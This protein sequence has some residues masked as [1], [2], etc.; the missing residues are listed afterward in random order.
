[1]GYG[2]GM[3]KKKQVMSWMQGVGGE[4]AD[5]AKWGIEEEVLMELVKEGKVEPM[6]YRLKEEG[7]TLFPYSL[8]ESPLPLFLHGWFKDECRE[9]LKRLIEDNGVR[10]VVELGSWLGQSTLYMA[11]LLPEGG[12]VYA[13]DHWIDSG[14][15]EKPCVYKQFLSNVIRAQLT[16]RVVPIR[17]T[18]TEA[19]QDWEIEVDLIYVDASH[20]EKDVYQD[21]SVWYPIAKRCG[22]VLCGDDYLWRPEEGYPVQ[23]ALKR[24]CEKMGLTHRN[25]GVFWEILLK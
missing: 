9:G 16:E 5:P 19:A 13:I 11:S 20:E 22:A 21:I 23:K 18:T 2:A 8:I 17:T 1:M 10:T 14:D 24:F 7:T 25:S 3:D 6:G 4:V 15:L 12:K